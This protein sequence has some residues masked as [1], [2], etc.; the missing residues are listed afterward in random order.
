MEPIA[1]DRLTNLDAVYTEDEILTRNTVRQF[2][3]EKYLPLIADQ[4]SS[5]RNISH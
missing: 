1:L 3:A 4:Y 2:V 5:P